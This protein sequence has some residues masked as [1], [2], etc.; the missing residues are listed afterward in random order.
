MIPIESEVKQTKLPSVLDR[1][2]CARVLLSLGRSMAPSK[3]LA[4]FSVLASLVARDVEGFRPGMGMGTRSMSMSHG[5][6]VLLITCVLG[7]LRLLQHALCVQLCC[8]VVRDQGEF[9]L[10]GDGE[11]R[12]R[13]V[14]S[15]FP[16]WK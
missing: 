9:V 11:A 13:S 16:E 7:T 3:T 8:R 1:G 12:N 4:A 14:Q 5:E 10:A 6:F 15:A 2:V